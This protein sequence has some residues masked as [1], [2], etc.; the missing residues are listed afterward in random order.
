[1]RMLSDGGIIRQPFDTIAGTIAGS[2]DGAIL[3]PGAA[4]PVHK[5]NV[6]QCGPL[7][8]TKAAGMVVLSQELLTAQT[9][10]EGLI[11]RSLRRSVGAAIDR[12]VFATLLLSTP[13]ALTSQGLLQDAANLLSALDLTDEFRPYYIAS[14]DVALRIATSTASGVQDFPNAMWNGGSI[15]GV[16]L[17]VSGGL[18]PYHLLL[19]DAA[20]L[21]GNADTPEVGVSAQGSIQM[22]SAPTMHAGSGSPTVPTPSTVVSLWQSNSVAVRVIETFA[23][24]VVS[25]NAI[26][27][28]WLGG[29]PA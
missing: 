10:A 7:L 21:A 8:R 22:N 15:Y 3:V 6:A 16:P 20:R 28:V 29:S 12:Q 13:A 14:P 26:A 23:C 19:V 5:M 2:A 27:S 9:E 17:L 1:M 11:T 18:D 4:I 25:P 24:D